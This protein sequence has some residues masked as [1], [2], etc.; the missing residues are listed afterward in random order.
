MVL[1]Q[2]QLTLSLKYVNS[3]QTLSRT[4]S[5]V[6]GGIFGVK[7]GVVA[8]REGVQVPII[9]TSCIEEVENRGL[10]ETGLYR[11]S[12]LSGQ[13]QSLKK[14]YERNSRGAVQLL[15]DTDIHVVTCLLKLYYRELPE[16]LFTDHLYPH[17]VEG[18]SLS[19]PE[20]DHCLQSGD[21]SIS[22]SSSQVCVSILTHLVR[23]SQTAENKMSINNLST[24]FG[25]TLLKPAAKTQTSV[26][27]VDLFYEGTRD[28]MMQT[29]IL[30]Y[31]LTLR[32]KGRD[33]G[34]KM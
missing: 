19:D 8:T 2:V 12:G 13:I 29:S 5:A 24:V 16:A 31:F 4:P 33:F 27:S 25:P 3:Q 30:H 1:I 20:L 32:A 17:L 34:I 6:K 9:V 28:V 14:A 11:V 21:V 23:V 10:G 22:H 18:I 7:L 15:A 26:V